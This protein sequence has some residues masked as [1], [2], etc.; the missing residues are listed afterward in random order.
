[1][2]N[3]SGEEKILKKVVTV[4]QLHMK[5]LLSVLNSFSGIH[6]ILIGNVKEALN[7][8]K[9]VISL[10]SHCHTKYHPSKMINRDKTLYI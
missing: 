3:I 2:I 10:G 1:M 6:V 7:D 5:V 8:S 4:I 9:I